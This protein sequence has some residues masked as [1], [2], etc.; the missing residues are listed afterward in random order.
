MERTYNYRIGLDIGITSVGWAVLENNSNDEPVHIMDLG[1]RIFDAAENPKTGASLAGPRREARSARRRLRRRRHRMERI[2]QLLE[3][4]G[5]IETETFMKRYHSADL[6][7]VYRLR[8]EALDRKLSDEELAQVL[9]HIAKHRGFQS[10]RKAELKEDKEAGKVLAATKENRQRLAAGNYRTVGEMIYCDEAFRTACAWNE[11]GYILTPRNKAE[12]YKHTVERALLV[13][14]VKQIFEAQRQLGND[15]ASSELEKR[16]LTLMESQ[17]S[18]DLGPGKQADGSPSPYALDGYGERVG[19]CTLEPEEKRGAK[20]AYTAE[21]FVALQKLSHLRVVAQGGES[22]PLKP[23]ERETILLLLHTQKEVKYSA[24]RKKLGLAPEERFNSLTYHSKDREETAEER[25]AAVE[26]AVFCK[27]E[28]YHQ[29]RKCLNENTL[30]L[31]EEERTELLD[32]IGTILTLYKNDDSRTERLQ[33]L[34]LSQEEI[35]ALLELTFAKFMHLSVL[36]MKKIIPF[37]REGMTY[38]KACSAAGYDFKAE[39]NERK[40]RLLKGQQVTDI[41]NDIPN[42]VVKRSVSQTVKVIN[43]II[44]RY[45][46]PQAVYIELAREMSKN[47]EERKRIEKD[48]RERE[49]DNETVKKQLQEYGILSPTGQDI[50]KFRLWQDQDCRCIYS[51]KVISIEELLGKSGGCDVDHILPYSITFDDSYRNKVLV[52][53]EENRQKGNRTP[54]EYMGQDEEKWNAYV[55]RVNGLIRDGRKRDRLLKEHI[56]DEDRKQFKERNLNDTKYITTIVYNLIRQNLEL[57]PYQSP[58]KKRQ[59]K[60]VNGAITAYLRKR[61]GLPRKDRSTDTHHAMDA[62]VIAC[63][64]EGMI[65]R[66]SRSMQAIELRYMK[67]GRMIDEETGEIFDRKKYSLEEWKDQFGVKIPRPWPA[68]KTELEVRMGEDPVGFL[69]THLDVAGEIGYPNYYY[70]GEGARKMIRPIFVSRMPN[71]KVTG[72][73]N[74]DTVRSPKIY[75]ETGYVISKRPLTALKLNKD[76][77]IADYYDKDSDR[78]LYAALKRQLQLY[79]N[80]AKKAFAEPFYKPKADGTP[81]PLVKKVKIMEKMTAGV[82]VYEGKGIASNGSMVRIDVFCENGKYYFVPIY[83]ADVVKKRLP[84]KA[85]TQHKQ[86][87][88]W[89]EMK[90]E[91]FVFS[92]YPKDLIRVR[93][94]KEDG[95]K[96]NLVNG[97]QVNGQEKLAYFISAD[98]AT[99]SIAGKAPDSS[100]SFRGLGIQS[101]AKFEKCQVD[102]LGNVSV[103]K[104]EKRMDF[105]GCKN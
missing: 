21:L 79:S 17:R 64:T 5:L 70:E 25:N 61:W 58:G 102:M 62:V 73:A 24:I 49:A 92:L 11:T 33:K 20:A 86:Y 38:D 72:Q 29:I 87:S 84:N 27:M 59:V 96:L 4:E 13:E 15:K 12:D 43:A 78:L 89:R 99:A 77:E 30:D 28:R 7:D 101:L 14:E 42:P 97:G 57:A 95:L 23:E 16:Y 94:K 54:Y 45:G 76:G 37:L 48:Q 91:D 80:D 100:F 34:P 103:V 63:C 3:S 85:A 71:H 32:E 2:R 82:P 47:F 1:V 65:N 50:I 35:D 40:S 10:N 66:I 6:P 74:E 68:F 105:S 26:K 55:A 31:P 52:T 104:Q 53:S 60:A 98:I 8:Y 75:A 69:D 90:D 51:G 46:S 83:A 9:V 93:T 67:N 36:A 22:R 18:F 44:Q 56:S 88:D 41:I 39:G 81:G 19:Q